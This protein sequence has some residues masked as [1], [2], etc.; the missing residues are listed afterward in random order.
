MREGVNVKFDYNAND[1]ASNNITV[2]AQ[3]RG[4][5]VDY[6]PNGVKHG[7]FTGSGGCYTSYYSII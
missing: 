3:L 6:L 4:A 7:A 1:F 2:R 5:L